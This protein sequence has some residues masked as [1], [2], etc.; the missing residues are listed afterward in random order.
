MPNKTTEKKTLTKAELAAMVRVT[1]AEI[2]AATVAGT[3]SLTPAA[4]QA[5]R[6][7]ESLSKEIDE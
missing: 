5:T 4:F 3:I 7:L 2:E 6:A 1:A